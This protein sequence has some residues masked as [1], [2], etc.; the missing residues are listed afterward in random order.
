MAIRIP[1]TYVVP[2]P[3][4]R[5]HRWSITVARNQRTARVVED[6]RVTT[7]PVTRLGLIDRLLSWLGLEQG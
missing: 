5:R 7:V 2:D 3:P 6:G 1:L 4:P